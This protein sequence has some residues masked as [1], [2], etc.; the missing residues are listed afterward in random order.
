MRVILVEDSALFRRGLARLLGDAGIEVVAE[1]ETA[2]ALPAVVANEDVEVVV[3]DIRMPP[4]HT[5]EGIEAA[6]ELRAK[7]PDLGVL[8]LSQYVETDYAVTLLEDTIGGVGYLLKDRV[9][10]P[11]QLIDAL[12]RI[13]AGETVVDGE[14]VG[15]LVGRQRRQSPLDGLTGRE[16][17]VLSAMAEG[18]SNAAIGDQ[19]S[20]SAKTVETH[21]RAI[22]QKLGLPADNDSHRR[23]L[24]VLTWLRRQQ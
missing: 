11:D 8:V 6:V 4:T 24:A 23:V 20:M 18:R 16:Q 13:A 15:R 1:L 19:L 7:R 17:D 22:F 12:A 9:T 2:E 3:L 10:D 5:T 14:V 21:I